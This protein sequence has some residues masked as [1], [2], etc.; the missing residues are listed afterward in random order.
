M[1]FSI[2]WN[3]NIERVVILQRRLFIF[4]LI[5]FLVV[6]L[7]RLLLTILWRV[8]GLLWRRIVGLRREL[9]RLSIGSGRLARSYDKIYDQSDETPDKYHKKPQDA[10]LTTGFRIFVD[11]DPNAYLYSE[12]GDEKDATQ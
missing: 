3:D 10:I 6:I 9:L 11:P 8:V 2:A 1:K 12:H 4:F 7:R 5:W